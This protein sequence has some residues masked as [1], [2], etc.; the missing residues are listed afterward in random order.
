MARK[1]FKKQY[2]L[3][4]IEHRTIDVEAD[5]EEDAIAW[6]EGKINKYG[7]VRPITG[8]NFKTIKKVLKRK[9]KVI[10]EQDSAD[11]I[12]AR[13]KRQIAYEAGQVLCTTCGKTRAKH[14]FYERYEQIYLGNEDEHQYS[15]VEGMKRMFEMNKKIN[16]MYGH[17]NQTEFDKEDIERLKKLGISVA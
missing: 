6:A 2:K 13:V 7:V 14:H 11:V 1:K 15:T 17:S 16:E 9:A 8:S 12:E 3:K 5:S 4:I 10:S